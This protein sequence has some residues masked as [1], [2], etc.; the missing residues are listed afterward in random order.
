VWSRAAVNNVAKL[1]DE[2]PVALGVPQ[3]ATDVISRELL[4]SVYRVDARI[5]PCSAGHRH[6]IVDDVS[7]PANLT[8]YPAG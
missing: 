5:E 3:G 7:E 1:D 2:P 6:V 8:G 4:R